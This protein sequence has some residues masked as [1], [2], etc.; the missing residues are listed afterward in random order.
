MHWVIPDQEKRSL[1]DEI[2]PERCAM[3]PSAPKRMRRHDIR[4]YMER[5]TEGVVGGG[6]YVEV[7][8]GR[9]WGVGG[10]VAV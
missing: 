7:R 2:E 4:M 3:G 10:E 8:G 5:Q 9:A 6:G 1:E